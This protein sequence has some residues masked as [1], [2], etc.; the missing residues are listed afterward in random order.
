MKKYIVMFLEAVPGFREKL[1]NAVES[2]IQAE[3][4]TQ[5][6]GFKTKWIM[7]GMQESINL[8][9]DIEKQCIVTLFSQDHLASSFCRMRLWSARKV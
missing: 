8:A 2:G 4:A 3:I 1:L 5:I 6:H 7:L 9:D